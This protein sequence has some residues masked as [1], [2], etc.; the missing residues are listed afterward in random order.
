MEEW[1]IALR[2]SV[3][4]VSRTAPSRVDLRLAD[5]PGPAGQ[6]VELARR[7]KACCE[8]FTFTVEIDAEGATVVV[9]VPDDAAAVL[10]GFG[11]LRGS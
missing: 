2:T 9:Q 6:L 11:G 7:E 3:A 8:F 5:G 1:H 4:K 10:D